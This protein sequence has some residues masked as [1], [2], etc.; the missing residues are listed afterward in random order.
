MSGARF[1]AIALAVVAT[2]LTPAASAQPAA[3]GAGT[4]AFENATPLALRPSK[5]LELVQ[6]APHAGIGWKLV[7]IAAV[8]GGGAYCLRRRLS[9]KPREEGELTIVRRVSLGMRSELVVVNVEGQRL[10]LGVTP[11]AIQSL[12]LLEANDD[13]TVRA[14][15]AGPTSGPFGDRFDA[16]LDA[17]ER[18]VPRSDAAARAVDE[19]TVAGQA[20]GL[21]A[22]RRRG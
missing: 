10:L 6:E 1:T 7:A 2:T 22:L 12:S 19:R 11:H 21:L 13:A 16:L 8:L 14:P 4:G 3:A 15:A 18:T 5:P 9:I 20:R 17:A